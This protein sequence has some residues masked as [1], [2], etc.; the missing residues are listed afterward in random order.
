MADPL[1][2]K[3]Q[4]GRRVRAARILAECDKVSEACALIEQRTGVHI[5]ERTLYALERGE[6][7]MSLEQYTAIALG[8]RPPSGMAFFA[9]AFNQDLMSWYS[10]SADARGKAG[11][12]EIT[13]RQEQG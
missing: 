13:R 10:E 1:I 12:D 9:P 3:E 6:Q 7:M 2:N 5:S 4:L 8:L 11:V